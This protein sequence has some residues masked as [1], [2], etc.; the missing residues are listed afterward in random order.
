MNVIRTSFSGKLAEMDRLA[1]LIDHRDIRRLVAN[2]EDVS[3]RPPAD[4]SAAPFP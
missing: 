2:H 4:D 3:G 1:I